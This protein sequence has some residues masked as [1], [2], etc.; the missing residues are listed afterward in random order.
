[1]DGNYPVMGR[2]V[3]KGKKYR[4]IIFVLFDFFVRRV[5]IIKD[6]GK[7]GKRERAC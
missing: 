4:E 7:G 3:E 5:I 1:M 2:S 6:K